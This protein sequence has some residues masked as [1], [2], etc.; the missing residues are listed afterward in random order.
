MEETVL[1]RVTGV[2]GLA[3]NEVAGKPKVLKVTF[4][5]WNESKGT[6]LLAG[7]MS[8]GCDKGC[9]INHPTPLPSTLREQHSCLQ[10]TVPGSL[11]QSWLEP[12]SQMLSL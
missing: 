3:S 1:C 7:S 4:P 12:P 11:G 6:G 5:V 10:D 2:R 9:R 8:S